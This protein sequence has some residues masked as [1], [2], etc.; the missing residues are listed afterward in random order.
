MVLALDCQEL[1]RLPLPRARTCQNLNIMATISAPS[2]ATKDEKPRHIDVD[3]TKTRFSWRDMVKCGRSSDSGGRHR[4]PAR[5][6]D[7]PG[8]REGG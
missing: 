1:P 5:L 7:Q 2:P 6:Q 4:A 3:Q 8:Q